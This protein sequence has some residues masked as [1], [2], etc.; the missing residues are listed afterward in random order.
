METALGNTIIK[1][2]T[3]IKLETSL[4]ACKRRYYLGNFAFTLKTSLLIRKHNCYLEKCFCFLKHLAVSNS[5][6]K[7]PTSKWY[8]QLGGSKVIAMFPCLFL[9]PTWCLCFWVKF[10]SELLPMYQLWRHNFR[11]SKWDFYWNE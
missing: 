4:L 5:K 7:F 2:V 9:F 3:Q 11:I 10:P 1:L 6:V 8:L